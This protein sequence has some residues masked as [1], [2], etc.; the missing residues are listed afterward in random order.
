MSAG[1]SS[2]AAR[3]PSAC[4][5][6]RFSAEGMTCGPSLPVKGVL[7]HKAVSGQEHTPPVEQDG[8]HSGGVAR[9]MDRPWP[10]RRL[11]CLAV[12]ECGYLQDRDNL[13]PP[14][15]HETEQGPPCLDV[16]QI[17]Q[18][19]TLVLP[20][21][22]AFGHGDVR[23]V[24]PDG[25]A[26]VRPPPFCEPGVIRMGMGEQDRLQ[27]GHAAAE[28]RHRVRE[29]VPVTRRSRV[30]QEQFLAFLNQVQ[31]RDSVRQTMDARRNLDG[32]T[33]GER[34]ESWA[35]RPAV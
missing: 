6:S 16:S 13:R 8:A 2:S 29:Q 28:R 32:I 22:P 23:F 11:D 24:N 12:R 3:D 34:S 1:T 15:T 18:R 21:G 14:S 17:R 26:R 27:L 9:N 7:H 10:S 35:R 30:D 4:L 31:V 33:S 25:G 19:P 20:G 5:V